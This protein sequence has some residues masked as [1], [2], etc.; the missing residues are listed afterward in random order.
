MSWNPLDEPYDKVWLA[1]K[2]SPGLC[3]IEGANS[4]R[5]WEERPGYGWSGSFLWFKGIRLAHFSLR[6]RLYT[7]DDWLDWS[8]FKPLLDRPPAGKRPRALDVWHPILVDQGIYSLVVEDVGQPT[9]TADG[10]WSIE[11]K[12]IEYRVP[13]YSLAKPDGAKATPVDPFEQ[14]IEQ[15]TNKAIDLLAA[16]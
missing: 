7:S 16:P 13:K 14:Q 3:D 9:Q 10:E 11:V 5:E 8:T 6:F 2:W 12:C 15:L 4:P 1:Q